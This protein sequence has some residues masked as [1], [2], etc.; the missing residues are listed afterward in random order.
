MPNPRCPA[1]GL[2]NFASAETCKRCGT[3]LFEESVTVPP[4]VGKIESPRSFSQASASKTSAAHGRIL[5]KPV[6][7]NGTGVDLLGYRQLSADTYQVTRCF[8][9]IHIPLI[10]ISTWVIRPLNRELSTFTTSETFNFE[11]LE[12]KGLI[13]EDALRL[14]GSFLLWGVLAFGP[15]ALSLMLISGEKVERDQMGEIVN[16]G[17]ST[18]KFIKLIL[19]L[20]SMPWCIGLILWLK[21]RRD[22][23]YTLTK[24]SWF[25]RLLGVR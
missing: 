17:P 11:L 22:K 14:Y 25:A 3:P 24:K 19:F 23:I 16:G 12:D 6:T 4:G 21:R 15:F 1:C 13:V 9:F 8:T 20:L 7:I 18:F 10:P 2:V 5:L